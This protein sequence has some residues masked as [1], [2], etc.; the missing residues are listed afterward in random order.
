MKRTIFVI[1]ISLLA[2]FCIGMCYFVFARH[3]TIPFLYRNKAGNEYTI[4]TSLCESPLIVD[5]SSMVAIRSEQFN[6]HPTCKFMADPFVVREGDDFYIFYEEM[7]AKMNSTW[8]DIAVLHSKN[9]KDWERIGVALD[10]PFHLSFPNVFKYG[11]EWYMI[12][13]T[14]AIDEIRLYKATD[15]PLKWAFH[16]T[17]IPDFYGVDPA[18]V[19]KDGIWYLMCN[20]NDRLLLFSSHTLTGNYTKHPCSPIRSGIQETRLAGPVFSIDDTLFYSTQRHDGGYGTGVVLFRIDSLTTDYFKDSRLDNNPIVYNHGNEFARD[21]MHQFSVL[22]VSEKQQYITV[23]DGCRH[24]TSTVW[25][26]DWHNFPTFR[27]Q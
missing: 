25:G 15:F 18:L 22:F 12:P 11:G 8:G 9:L 13:E 23:M 7:S 14:S 3:M 1:I 2:L 5:T 26:W 20:S 6:M 19:H 17:L 16:A 27:F 4:V 10:E 21:G 24:A